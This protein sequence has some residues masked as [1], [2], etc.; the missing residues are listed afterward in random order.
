MNI[1]ESLVTQTI[2]GTATGV[3]AGSTVRL[4]IGNTT[5][6]AIVNNDGTFSA[7]VS[8]AILA[9]LLGGNFT[10]SASVTDAVGNTTSTSGG[11]QLGLT[12]PTLTVNTVLGDG[13]LSAA[14][15]ASNQ[16]ISGHRIWLPGR[17][18]VLRSTALPIQ[19]K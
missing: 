14:D 4:A 19:R 11:V 8:P 10:V 6:T 13:I 3:A 9:T 15:L 5:A 7:T 2:S 16:T 1:A 18:S 17:R 12:Q